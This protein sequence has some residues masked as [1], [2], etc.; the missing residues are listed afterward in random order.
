MTGSYRRRNCKCG[1]K[2]CTCGAK[3]TYRYHIIDPVTGKRK[4]KETPGFDTK[5]EAEA[6]ARKI[7]SKLDKGVY[8]DEKNITFA[9]FV[10]EFL[11]LYQATGRV[12]D[13][14]VRIRE[15]RCKILQKYF[16]NIK[17]SKITRKMYQDALIKMKE[18]GGK[19]KDKGYSQETIISTHA[20]GRM[21]FRK[22]K[23]LEIIE[24]NPAEHAIVPGEQKTIEQ[25]ES[26]NTLPFFMEKDE[27]AKFLR[28]IPDHAIDFQ[29]HPIFVTLAY[30]GI[31]VGE[32]CSLKWTDLD[33]E[34]MTISITKTLSNKNNNIK[35]YKL[36]P[37]KTKSSIRLIEI[38]QTVIN[39]LEEQ[40]KNQNIL[41]MKHRDIYH[42]E[43]FIF[44]KN[45]DRFRYYGYPFMQKDI[46]SRMKRLLI[47]A[48]LNTSL[49]PHSLRHTHTSLLAAAGVS[50]ETIQDRLG[51]KNDAITRMVYLHITKELKRE[52]SQKFEELMGGL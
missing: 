1:K 6:E 48:K 12:K 14:S 15:S 51:H 22:A 16:N 17:L 13:G 50:L 25:I 20:T 43:D 41:K 39:A 27:L 30:T 26:N 9:E 37:P 35:N 4:Q 44:T 52:A 32:L 21:L 3:W 8:I 47:E 24:N 18:P 33:K 7:Q 36:V 19:N 31:R 11:K 23:E 49:T 28:V 34:N 5:A 46:G 45:N 40:R 2:R 10:P 29:D 38:S 42:D